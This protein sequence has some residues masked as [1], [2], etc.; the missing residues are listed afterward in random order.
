M[1]SAS[2]PRYLPTLLALGAIFL[3][4][5]HSL[6]HLDRFPRIYEDEAWIAAPGYTFWSDGRFG[7]ELF[8]GFY[9]ME[10]H[11][12][13]FMPLFPL[14][15][16]AWLKWGGMGL[17][18][19]R[20]AVLMLTLLTLALTHRL[21]AILFSRWH[22][23]AAVLILTFWRIAT[24]L[25]TFKSGIPMADLARIARYDMAAA[26]WG[27]AA[28][29]MTAQMIRSQASLSRHFLIGILT[30]LATLSHLYGAF[31]LVV[32][33]LLE[34]LLLRRR[35]LRC[36]F[37]TG[38]G[39]ALAMS[40][41][42][43]FVAGHWDDFRGQTRAFSDRFA[44]SEMAFY[45]SSLSRELDRYQ[46]LREGFA[47]GFIGARLW[48]IGGGLSLIWLVYRASQGDRAAQLLL[49]SA[50]VLAGGF[51]LLI[52]YKTFSYLATLFPLLALMIAAGM[53]RL[54]QEIPFKRLGRGLLLIVC[55]LP[56]LEGQQTLYELHHQAQISTPYRQFTER[57]AASL[58]PQSRVLGMQH[59]WLG[60]A[61]HT[62]HYRSILVP[63]FWTD[64]SYVTQPITFGAAAT[65]IP[66]D[67]LLLDE[68]MLNFLRQTR[69]P[70][71]PYHFLHEQIWAYLEEQQAELISEFYDPTYG[72]MKIYQL[73][74]R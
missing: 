49:I 32:V 53:I 47:I 19:V 5:T 35:R 52:N 44:L 70:A 9:G 67:Y 46:P 59:Y 12:Y 45:R 20:L 58:P 60:L 65:A 63:I 13:A 38:L 27:L 50:G 2:R 72:Q 33:L 1:G 30:G 39:F 29:A 31:W 4:W 24:P 26:F 62:A 37:V 56:M 23:A 18:Q 69:D 51:A 71:D 17:L 10:Q 21:G 64:P 54:W 74:K 40:F 73:P 11:Y 22:G 25:P 16:G 7:S 42:L 48:I 6:S 57:I 55:L 34:G 68:V 14:W 66:P 3:F 41:W 8:D 36:I 28:L 43:A 61:E 15:A